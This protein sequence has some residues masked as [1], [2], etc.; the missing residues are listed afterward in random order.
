M[1]YFQSPDSPQPEATV[2][3]V[4]VDVVDGQLT[5]PDITP[6]LFVLP[7]SPFFK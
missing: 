2:A 4:V 1:L 5:L 6:I 7:E 3:V